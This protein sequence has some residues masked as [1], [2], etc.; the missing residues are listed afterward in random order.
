ME[1]LHSTT[2]LKW[3]VILLAEFDYVFDFFVVFSY[4]RLSLYGRDF[5]CQTYPCGE[6][7]RV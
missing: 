5:K 2:K 1:I 7:V 4:H 3:P 6:D